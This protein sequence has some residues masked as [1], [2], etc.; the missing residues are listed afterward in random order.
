LGSDAP[1]AALRLALQ[2][3]RLHTPALRGAVERRRVLHRRRPARRRE[4]A[5]AG[6][7]GE[8]TSAAGAGPSRRLRR[9]T[10]SA[11]APAARPE[12]VA[13]STPPPRSAVRTEGIVASRG[14]R[15]R[16]ATR[17]AGRSPGTTVPLQS[18]RPPMG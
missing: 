11:A 2:R 15:P 14:T 13:G 1:P 4:G 8:R 17:V 10:G 5:P 9:T 12:V 18:A 6:A 3:Q 7:P 16:P